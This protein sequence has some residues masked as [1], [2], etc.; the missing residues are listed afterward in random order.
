MRL[1]RRRQTDYGGKALSKA[2]Q[3][4]K[5]LEDESRE[6]PFGVDGSKL[7]GF[8]LESQPGD[9]VFFNQRL[10]HSSF[11]GKTGRRMF[12]LNYGEK[13]INEDHISLVKMVYGASP[14]DELS[15]SPYLLHLCRMDFGKQKVYSPYLRALLRL[16]RLCYS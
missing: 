2:E 14:G 12:T 13:L 10:W 8:P 9:V 7:P 3:D 6:I 4:S 11:G 15:T 16:L 5:A 1:F